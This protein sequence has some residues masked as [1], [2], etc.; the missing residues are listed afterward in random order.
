M[1]T[2]IQWANGS[3]HCACHC[4]LRPPPKEA[5]LTAPHLKQSYALHGVYEPVVKYLLLLLSI[6][7]FL[8]IPCTQSLVCVGSMPPHAS[9]EATILWASSHPC[10]A[11]HHYLHPYLK[12]SCQQCCLSTEPN[13]SIALWSMILWTSASTQHTF[14]YSLPPLHLRISAAS[15]MLHASMEAMILLASACQSPACCCFLLPQT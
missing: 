11:Y 6:Y 10:Q 13:P 14:H 9:M 3:T 8:R 15:A 4:Y 1:E 12:N 5:L 7:F 2:M